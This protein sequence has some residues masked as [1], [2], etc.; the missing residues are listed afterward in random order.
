MCQVGEYLINASKEVSFSLQPLHGDPHV[1]N[2]LNTREGVLLCD[3]ESVCIGPLEWDLSSL[4]TDIVRFYNADIK[5]LE[6]MRN[7]RSWLVAAWCWMYLGQSKEKEA[8]AMH[9]LNWLKEKA[10]L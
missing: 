7:L 4:P 1:G 8:A 9:H 3:F 6:M 5:I 10:I 2:F